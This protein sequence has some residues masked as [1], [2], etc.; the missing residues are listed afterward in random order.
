VHSE[1]WPEFDEKVLAA[2]SVTM[3][4]QVNGK[5]RGTFEATPDM[6]DTELVKSA[7]AVETVKAHLEGKSVEREIVVKGRMV[8]L[9]VK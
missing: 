8:S 4:V 1:A 5:T 9:V 2:A 3:A 6:D 7:K